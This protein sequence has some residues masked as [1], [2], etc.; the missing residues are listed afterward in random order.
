MSSNFL[1]QQPAFTL[2]PVEEAENIGTGPMGALSMQLMLS[3]QRRMLAVDHA[4]TCMGDTVERFTAIAGRI[5]F[6]QIAQFSFDRS[7]C[8]FD[9]PNSSTTETLTLYRHP[10][11]NAILKVESYKSSVNCAKLF[12]VVNPAHDGFNKKAKTVI[13]HGFGGS[14]VSLTN[15]TWRYTSE[16]PSDLVFVGE[17]DVRECLV[18]LHQAVLSLDPMVR[19]QGDR[20]IIDNL[21]TTYIDYQK[22]QPLNWFERQS[23][24]HDAEIQRMESLGLNPEEFGYAS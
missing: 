3:E 18:S 2:D 20:F 22:V 19:P 15:Q 7:I 16:P 4:D 6:V 17:A 24:L 9:S 23:A 11:S 12:F 21:L 8:D 10:D 13:N 5:G 1:H 14:W